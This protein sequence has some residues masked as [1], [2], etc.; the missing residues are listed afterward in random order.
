M[1][2]FFIN[3]I[4]KIRDNLTENPIYKPTRKRIPSLA[5]FRPFNKMGVKIILSMKT[6]SCELDTLPTKLLKDCLDDISPT[7]TNLVNISLQDGVFASDWKTLVIRPL[8]NKANLDLILSSY[9]PVSNLPFLSKLLE[10]CAMDCVNEHCKLHILMPDYQS[11][12][13]NGYSCKTVIIRL[14][15]DIL[16]AMEYQNVTALIALDLSAALDTVD[17]E[18]CQMY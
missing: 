7:I 1:L 8:I 14:M 15:N 9:H 6:K 11:A 5:E 17:H 2:A 13:Q 10:K 3:K 18:F 16:W 12:Y 4:Q